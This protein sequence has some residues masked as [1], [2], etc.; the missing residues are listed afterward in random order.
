MRQEGR[1]EMGRGVCVV[2]PTPLVN[3]RPTPRPCPALPTF[4]TP[5]CC[6]S[7]PPATPLCPP[8]PYACTLHS[9]ACTNSALVL[10]RPAPGVFFIAAYIALRYFRSTS[11]T[12][13]HCT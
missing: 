12:A 10:S 9:H 13:L 4:R 3:K 2:M 11:C 7:A 6:P 8:C 5:A 1:E